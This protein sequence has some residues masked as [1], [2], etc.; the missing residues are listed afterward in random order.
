[1]LAVEDDGP[2]IPRPVLALGPK[3]KGI[4]SITA[5]VFHRVHGEDKGTRLVYAV[6]EFSHGCRVGR[7]YYLRGV[8]ERTTT[9]D[10][11]T[12]IGANCGK[13]YEEFGIL[14]G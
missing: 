7:D 2:L 12:K 5:A 10:V 13:S 9:V 11:D 8:F 14:E 1:V 3:L 6:I 4:K